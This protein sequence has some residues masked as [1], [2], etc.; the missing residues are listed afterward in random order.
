MADRTAWEVAC[1]PGMRLTR[2]GAASYIRA[3]T[4]NDL[5]KRYGYFLD[6]LSR[7]GQLD[8]RPK[9]A[10]TSPWRM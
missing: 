3:V 4:Q 7:S 2:G 6:F 10:L 8:R 1:R 5:A 9:L